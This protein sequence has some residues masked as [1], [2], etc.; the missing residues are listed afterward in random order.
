MKRKL[1]VAAVLLGLW[2]TI[3]LAA[4]GDGEVQ[5]SGNGSNDNDFNTSN[6][7]ASTSLRYYL[8]VPHEIGVRQGI[9]IASFEGARDAWNGTTQGF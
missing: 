8:T 3:I 2:P 1:R 5:L 6:F 4:Q 9:S 7:G